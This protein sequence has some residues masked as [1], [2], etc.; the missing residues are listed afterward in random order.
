VKHAA[1][2]GEI[3]IRDPGHARERMRERNAS[4]VDV[5][6]AILSATTAFHQPRNGTIKLK[7]GADT[8][9]D[10]LTVVVVEDPKGLRLV[11]V[12]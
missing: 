5:K 10:E 11:T 12:M 2:Y 4:A 1:T 3:V 6:R 9:G 7:G 8:D